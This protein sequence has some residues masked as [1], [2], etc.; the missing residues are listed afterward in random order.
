MDQLQSATIEVLVNRQPGFTQ[1]VRLTAVGFVSGR[2][3]ITKSLGVKEVTVKSDARTA[4]LKLTANIDSETGVRQILV[5]GEATNNGQAVVEFSQPV[6]L[7]V[8]QIPFVLS[9]TPSKISL[10]VPPAGSTNVDEMELKV[11]VDRRGF[12][13]ELPLVLSGLPEG[14]RVDATNIAANAVELV[15]KFFATDKT[16]P[17]TNA[18]VTIQA[19]AMFNDRLYRHKTGGIK[20]VVSPPATVEVAATNAVVTPK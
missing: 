3:P 2:E 10:N 8:T 20:V 16:P 4:Q 6:A 11:R 13:G 19:A 14:V 12:T 9:A 15:M 5:R 7:A 17:T 18:T 1:D